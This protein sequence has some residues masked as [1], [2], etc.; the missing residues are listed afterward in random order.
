VFHAPQASQR[1]DQRAWVAPQAVQ[2]N[3]AVGLAMPAHMPEPTVCVKRET[4]LAQGRRTERRG[5]SVSASGQPRTC[6]IPKSARPIPITI[7][8]SRTVRHPGG[9]RAHRAMRKSQLM[10]M[11]R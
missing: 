3:V 6:S 8:H 4:P 5:S 1:P 11:G 2:V 7:S 9:R 10:F